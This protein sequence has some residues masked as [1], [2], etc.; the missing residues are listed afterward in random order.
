MKRFVF[1]IFILFCFVAK[2]QAQNLIRN[3]SFENYHTPINWN[4]WGG[5]FIGY[6]IWPPDTVMIDWGGYQTPDHYVAACPHN[7]A[8]VPVNHV[9]F[10]YSKEGNAYVGLG[11]YQK[12]SEVKEYIYQQLS[13]PLQLGKIYCLSF[14]VNRSERT[15]FA[16]KQIGAYFS[17]SLPSTVGNTYINAN[18]KVVSNV[19]VVDTV[20]W[21]EIQ[22]CFTANGGEQYI[23]IGNF[24]S[25]TNTDTLNIGTNNP[26]LGWQPSAYYYIDDIT[27][28]D[29]STVGVSEFKNERSVE[30]HPNPTS[31]ILNIK[32]NNQQLQNAGIEIKN[33]LGQVVYVGMYSHQIDVS[34][35][36][37]G[38]YFITINKNESKQTIKFVKD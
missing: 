4:W 25:N 3:G 14:Y 13:Q 22:G 30:V 5:D 7:Y 21:I 32:S 17:P 26:V 24:N 31:S 33:T 23:I 16:I 34:N 2:Q 27:L 1:I 20:Q 36:P 12:N 11:P 35:L 9:G 19:F 29:Q 18:P 8:S 28:I 15:E 37:Q 10:N 6:Y 38:I